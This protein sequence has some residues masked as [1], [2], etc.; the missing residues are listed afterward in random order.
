VD[1]YS[2]TTIALFNKKYTLPE[3]EKVK[4]LSV[5]KN[6]HPQLKSSFFVNV[7][8]NRELSIS[9]GAV[10]NQMY[11]IGLYDIAGKQIVPSQVVHTSQGKA[12]M[13][14]KAP[15]AGGTYLVKVASGQA[16]ET[17]AVIIP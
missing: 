4:Y 8:R 11:T 5:K 3:D 12:T 15:L 2:I 10:H 13:N 9:F 17:R 7:Y 16:A 6:L 14:L 1:P